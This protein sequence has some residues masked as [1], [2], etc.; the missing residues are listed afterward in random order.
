M[1]L[2]PS[3]F[4]ADVTRRFGE[5]GS[6][7][8]A[9]L[10]ARIL[11]VCTRWELD[12]QGLIGFGTWS[13]VYA[14]QQHER[15]AALKVS[16]PHG[17]TFER[18]VRVLQLWSGNGAVRV[19][20]ADTERHALLLERLDAT[21][22]L[23]HVDI[24]EALRVAGGLLRRHAL[25]APFD[26]PTLAS[27][28][29]DLIDGIEAQ[30]EKLRRPMPRA[31]VERARSL[32]RH[33]L[34]DVDEKLVNWDVHYD[35]VLRGTREPWQV[36]DPQVV[37]GDVEYGVAQLL[38]WR[39]ED[40]EARGGVRWALDVL[41]EAAALDVRRLEGWVYVRTVAYWLSGLEGGLTVDP[42]R[43]R[44]V[45]AALDRPGAALTRLGR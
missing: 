24:E 27:L 44:Q 2:V 45:I 8:L 30:W 11:E 26:V 25:P 3:A 21:T 9:S 10:P 35:N 33:L 17:D 15:A 40:I 20:R 13:V 22:R 4:A 19:L 41:T 29:L 12:L 39:L 38:W 43:C 14:V 32:A 18:E 7:W 6:G 5:V 1:S 37:A 28:A 42:E 16:W 34:P 31:V 23:R 36:I